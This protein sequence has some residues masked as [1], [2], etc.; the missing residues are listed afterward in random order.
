[1]STVMTTGGSTPQNPFANAPVLPFELSSQWFAS[2]R[3]IAGTTPFS[4]L[5]AAALTLAARWQLD[6]WGTGQMIVLS[7][8]TDAIIFAWFFMG[9][10]VRLQDSSSSVL[11]AGRRALQGHWR[12]VALSSLWGLPAALASSLMFI[13]APEVIKSLIV[14]VGSNLVGLAGLVVALLLAA[15]LTFLLSMLPVLAAIQS[16]RDAHATFKV[17][18][19]WALRAL[20][21]G[22]RPLAAV[23][24]TFI[25]GCI[26]AGA[27]LTY[28]YGHLPVR[29][30]L[31]TPELD[32]L[33][34]YW[35][36]WP[37]LFVAMLVFLSI[38]HPMATDLLGAADLDLS[39]E[40]ADDAQKSAYGDRHVGW[41]LRRAGF[42]LR[43]LAAL[44][45]LL[46]LM[47]GLVVGSGEAAVWFGI[48]VVLYVVG[49]LCDRWGKRR[50]AQEHVLR[51]SETYTGAAPPSITPFASSLKSTLVLIGLV[52]S[53]LVSIVWGILVWF[54]SALAGPNEPELLGRLIWTLTPLIVPFWLWRVR[55]N[56]HAAALP[57]VSHPRPGVGR[58]VFSGLMW[59]ATIL[60][61]LFILA[62]VL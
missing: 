31:Q 49:K 61:T 37:G 58:Q 23:F 21:A 8:L 59:A 45:L 17:A 52:L 5:F 60:I 38:L 55:R 62:I 50:I 26:V 28:L 24:A 53:V 36:P 32:A 57:P 35:Y 11:R 29:W 7:Y 14:L 34:Q 20:R 51:Q 27:T 41:L 12:R 44:S 16:A 6:F 42:V 25:S 10:T 48:A 56:L 1:M 22:H 15:Y 54:F 2:G 19:L 40:I 46:G 47:Y 43:S 33:L 39:D 30:L 18:G 9:L 13:F 4:L 3:S